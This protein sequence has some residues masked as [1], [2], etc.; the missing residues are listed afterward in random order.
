MTVN[1]DNRDLLLF[2]SIA[3][4]S[5][6][7]GERTPT[8]GRGGLAHPALWLLT[9]T[10]S[11]IQDNFYF[12]PHKGTIQWNIKDIQ[13]QCNQF[14]SLA[15]SCPT[16]CNPRPPCPSPT[17]GVYPNSCPLSWWCHPTTSPSVIPPLH[18]LSSPSPPVLN[19]SQH[20]GLFKWV[21]SSHQVAK[22][23]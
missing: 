13:L 12:L 1:Y 9:Q 15:Q 21:T 3:F 23:L 16:L 8:C 18:P 22:V 17:P 14:S 5:H 19:I 10:P 20:H 4:Y 2:L 6:S 11:T 7:H